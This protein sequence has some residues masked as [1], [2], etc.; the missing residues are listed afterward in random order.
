M[1][2]AGE[3]RRAEADDDAF[4][5]GGGRGHGVAAAQVAGA[6]PLAGGDLH[7]PQR[8]AGPGVETE[9]VVLGELLLS[10][11]LGPDAGSDE[12]LAPDD[13]RTGLVLILLDL[14]V[15]AGQL[16]LPQDVLA[17]LAAPLEGQLLLVG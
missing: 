7:G 17:F 16:G 15:V 10:D 8:L 12:D 13:D 6:R 5:V 2:E 14:A 1:I 4:G 3:H 11:A 9:D